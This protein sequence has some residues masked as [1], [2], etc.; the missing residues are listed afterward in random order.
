MPELTLRT[1]PNAIDQAGT[2]HAFIEN[3]FFGAG[4][5]SYSLQNKLRAD[6]QLIRNE[7][8]DW[9]LQVRK[10]VGA[11]EDTY[12]RENLPEPTREQPFPDRSAVATARRFEDLQRKIE[13]IE[14]AVRSAPVPV[15]DRTWQRH[16]S[17]GDTASDLINIDLAI[18]SQ[19][20]DIMRQVAD[21]GSDVLQLTFDAL[22]GLLRERESAL[23]VLSNA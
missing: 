16:R 18:A 17:E 22:E 5:N 10:E 23:S 21:A 7:I 15:K 4:Y 20:V 14:T 3:L 8:C 2:V 1:V 13:A 9:L 6:D 12:R 11:R 19:V